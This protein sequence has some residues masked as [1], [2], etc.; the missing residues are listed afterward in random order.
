[1]GVHLRP[2]APKETDFEFLFMVVSSVA[3][4]SCFVWLASGLPWP[5]CWFRRLT[6]LPCPT[7]GATRSALS[8][9]HGDLAAA[10]RHN[11]LMFVCYVGTIL[12]NLYCVSV[13]LF[14]FP[15]LRLAVVPS[16]VK[17]C[18]C[19]FVI[20]AVALNWAY[21]LFGVPFPK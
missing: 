10:F 4:A 20:T 9:A 17:R 13:L 19:R 12:L 14:Q 21:L 3:A 7:C 5:E 11:P 16:D 1:M 2:L 6:G 8:L 18:L 15:R